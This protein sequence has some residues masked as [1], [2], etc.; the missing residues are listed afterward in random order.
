MTTDRLLT[1]A[2]LE[3]MTVLWTQGP[4]TARDVLAALPDDRAYT[5]IATILRILVDKGF[6][7]TTKRGRAHVFTPAVGRSEYQ[8]RKLQ[9]VVAGLFA[10]SPVDLV[11][12]LVKAE[13]L[14][15]ADR[16][17]LRRLVDEELEP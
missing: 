10:G 17:A 2:E 1:D 14:S 7:T 16:E 5:T 15:D 9:A 8:V 4:L 6:A 3:L 11:R 13:Q 12:Q